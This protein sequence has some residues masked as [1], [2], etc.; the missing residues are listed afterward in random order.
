MTTSTIS[1]VIIS[2]QNYCPIVTNK[3]QEYA[4]KNLE[5]K[6]FL[7]SMRIDFQDWTKKH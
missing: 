7:E 4:D 3:F 2:D 5:G 1:E 6:L